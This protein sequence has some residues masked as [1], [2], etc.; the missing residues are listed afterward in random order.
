MEILR[1]DDLAR[2]VQVVRSGGFSAAARVLGESPKLTSRR[3]G[4]LE[5]ALG[6][7]LLHRTTRQ[8]SLTPEGERYYEAAED[9]VARLDL[10]REGLD[11]SGALTGVLR[12]KVTTMMAEPLMA[13]LGEVLD[14]HPGLQVDVDVS[15]EPDDLVAGSLDVAFTAYPP[16]SSTLLVRCLG[17]IRGWCAA[18]ESY[19]ARCGVPERPEDL[20]SHRCL[21]FEQ[22]TTWVIDHPEHG[23]REVPVGDQLSV[24]DSRA[25]MDALRAGLGVG[26]CMRVEPGLVRVLPGWTWSAVPVYVL[27]A[28]GR[29]H[30]RRVRLVLDALDEIAER[31]MPGLVVTA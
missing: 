23:A 13:W 24:N 6:R 14:A 2:F 1:T 15:D 3:I 25:L 30:L 8:V 29:R 17:V 5:L 16:R 9:V 7:R 20:R 28:P 11:E 19:L 4:E 31:A 22:Q 21:R 18:H 26:L 27:I 10:A 12:L